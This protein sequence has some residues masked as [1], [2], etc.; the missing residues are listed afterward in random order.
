MELSGSANLQ[1]N[2]SA[3]FKRVCRLEDELCCPFPNLTAGVLEMRVK[4]GSKI[5]NLM[6]FSMARMQ[7]GAAL[8]QVVFSGSGRAVT[9]TITCAEIMKRKMPGLHQI[10]K[11]QYRGLR[12]VW[13]SQDR[14]D[15]QVTVHRTLP[16][17]SILLSK[18]PLDPLEPGYQP[19]EDHQDLL[20]PGNQSLKQDLLEPGYQP[21]KDTKDLL[22]PG[23]QPLKSPKHL[24]DPRFQVIKDPKNLL[25]PGSQPPKNQDGLDPGYQ[26]IKDPKNLLEPRY[27]PLKDTKDSLEPRFQ[28]IKDP[29][30][31]LEPRYQPIKDTKDLMDSRYQ[32]LKDPKD[33]L[34]ARYQLI[35]DPK[36]RLEPGYQHPL[37]RSGEPSA[38]CLLEPQVKRVC[39]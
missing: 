32:L 14:G 1:L 12:E 29:K 17:I 26:L 30:N 34:E 37:K 3:G 23:Y 31:L 9:K 2:N 22:E 13:E 4:E 21:L 27:Q 15:A 18:D 35:K 19:P 5:R 33:P 11:L 25:E 39:V 38:D 16:S 28:L 10:S 8:R 36:Q 6:G 20:E 7:D 24:L